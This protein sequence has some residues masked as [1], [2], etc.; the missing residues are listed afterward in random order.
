[1]IIYITIVYDLLYI[2]VNSIVIE[3][4]SWGLP[5]LWLPIQ[6]LQSPFSENSSCL[7]I[8]MCTL[9]QIFQ[10]PS[11]LSFVRRLFAGNSK[12][13]STPLMN[14]L[15]TRNCGYLSQLIPC[16]WCHWDKEYYWCFHSAL[17][18]ILVT[19]FLISYRSH[20]NLHWWPHNACVKS[21]NIFLFFHIFPSWFQDIRSTTSSSYIPLNTTKKAVWKTYQKRWVLWGLLNT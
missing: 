15:Q 6:S 2:I 3:D 7:K 8:K 14:I 19:Y 4:I 20:G 10:V 18:H 1:M 16:C 13:V 11:F 5:V 17:I 21:T 12:Q 9:Q